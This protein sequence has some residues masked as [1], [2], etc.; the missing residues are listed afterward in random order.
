M[1][2]APVYPEAARKIRLSG[3]VVLQPVIVLYTRT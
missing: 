1:H 3:M 2:V